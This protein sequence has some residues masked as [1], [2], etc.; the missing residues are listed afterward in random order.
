MKFFGEFE[1]WLSSV[2]V[3]T[4]LG[5][6]ILSLVLALGGGP[7]GD[8]TGFRY[9]SK[10]GAFNEYIAEGSLGRFLAVWSS[11]ITAVFAYLGTELVGV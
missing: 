7:N 10:P 3:I 2:K 1:F 5:V 11:M 4:I 9:W 8:R 6:I